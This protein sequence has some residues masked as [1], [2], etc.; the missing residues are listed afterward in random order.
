MPSKLLGAEQGVKN[1]P[2]GDTRPLSPGANASAPSPPPRP[3]AA[4]AAPASPGDLVVCVH[5]APPHSKIVRPRVDLAPALFVRGVRVLG[6]L[7]SGRCRETNIMASRLLG[8]RELE[9]HIAP[10]LSRK[11]ARREAIKTID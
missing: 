3:P 6:F 2:R 7:N 4:S 11:E 9:Y 1:A 5:V 8:F 10:S